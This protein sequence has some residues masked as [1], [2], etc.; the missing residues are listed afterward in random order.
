MKITMIAALDRNRVIGTGSG[1]LPWRLPRDVAQFRLYTRGKTLLIGRRTFEEMRGWFTDQTPIVLS[2]RRDFA[3]VGSLAAHTVDEAVGEAFERGAP[4][5]VVC[6]GA[7]VYTAALPY[8]DELRLTLVETAGDGPLRFPDYR[9]GHSWETLSEERHE[10]D[11]ENPLAMTFLTL[12][13]I[14]PSSLRPSRLHLL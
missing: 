5:L 8:A 3:P 14:S 9:A 12:R 1:G 11:A 4:E 2:H 6:G 13:R 10:A 7:A